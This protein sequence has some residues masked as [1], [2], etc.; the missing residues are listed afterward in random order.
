MVVGIGVMA[1]SHQEVG[2]VIS[3]LCRSLVMWLLWLVTAA[4]SWLV[5]RIAWLLTNLFPDS[6]TLVNSTFTP[7]ANNCGC[8]RF[9]FTVYVNPLK[10]CLAPICSSGSQAQYSNAVHVLQHSFYEIVEALSSTVG[11]REYIIHMHIMI[12]TK[13]TDKLVDP[14]CLF[15]L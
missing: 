3:A 11:G 15:H 1:Q 4:N 6:L 2:Q 5:S 10:L 7:I 9:E 12:K 13:K 8:T 14:F